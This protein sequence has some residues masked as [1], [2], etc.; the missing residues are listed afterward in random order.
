MHFG[1]VDQKGCDAHRPV[2]RADLYVIMA[3]AP[4]LLTRMH[5]QL[6]LTRT[7][8]EHKVLSY[9]VIIATPSFI[10]IIPLV[11]TCLVDA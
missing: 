7:H 8:R 9:Y 1:S 2:G 4:L 5:K 6:L 10:D 11:T 3:I